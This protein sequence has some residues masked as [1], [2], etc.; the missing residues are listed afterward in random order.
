MHGEFIGV[1]AETTREIWDVIE[2]LEDAPDDLYCELYRELSSA[3]KTSLTLEQLADIIDDPVQSKHA[4]QSV[5][6]E[7]LA[8]EHALVVFFENTHDVLNELADDSLSNP[9]FNL[10]ETFV[11]KFSLRY[12]LRR[13]CVLCPTIAGV[14]A[15]LMYDLRTITMKDTHL[16]NS[17]NELDSAIRDM[18]IDCTDVRIKTCIQKQI[19]LLEAMGSIFP[20]VTHNTLGA[21]SEQIN[22]WPH[23]KVKESMKNLYGFASDY[24]GIRHGGTPANAIRDIEMRDMV[25]MSILLIGFIPYL[26]NEIN[27]ET[28]YWRN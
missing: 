22:T 2:S 10:L 7:E 11:E 28:V 1:W 18:R 3:M 16:N 6:V 13:P 9:Y 20:G 19:N 5:S 24:P 4:F 27:I 8:G 26:S 23:Q 21:I 17:M 12:E 15:S 25:A 14:F